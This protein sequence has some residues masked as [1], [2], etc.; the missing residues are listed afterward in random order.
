MPIDDG[1]QKSAQNVSNVKVIVIAIIAVVATIFSA[2]IAVE[3]LSTEVQQ[4]LKKIDEH[5]T[6]ISEL[7][8]K[9]APLLVWGSS[10]S[11]WSGTQTE[12]RGTGASGGAVNPKPSICQ[13]GYYAV[14]VEVEQNTER[15]C[16][17]CLTGLRAI[18]RALPVAPAQ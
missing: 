7:Q 6:K 15:Y 1:L 18:C 5:E 8:G 14:G 11:K 4:R 9:V 16:V 12:A 2:G 17:G 3:K 10:L 13:E